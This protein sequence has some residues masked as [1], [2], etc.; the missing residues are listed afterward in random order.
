[1]QSLWWKAEGLGDPLVLVEAGKSLCPF[2]S[3]LHNIVA[4]TS[5]DPHFSPG[6][7]LHISP[8][9]P[10]ESGTIPGYRSYKVVAQTTLSIFDE[11]YLVFHVLSSGPM[12]NHPPKID[13][14]CPSV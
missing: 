10:Y 5:L 2:Q 14:A 6:L 11:V 13:G 9:A 1:M 12:F 4:E 8:Q 3:M 7:A